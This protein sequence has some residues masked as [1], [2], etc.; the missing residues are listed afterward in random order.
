MS[1]MYVGKSVHTNCI[2]GEH[3]SFM[4]IDL[5]DVLNILDKY[6]ADRDKED[7]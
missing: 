4:V 3:E 5:N 2:D 6:K 7:E 1:F